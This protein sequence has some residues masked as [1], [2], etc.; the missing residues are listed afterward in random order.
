MVISPRPAHAS[1]IGV[2]RHDVVVVGERYLTDG[3]LPVLLNYFSIE[4]FPHFCFG[5]TLAVSIAD[6]ACLRSVAP[7]AF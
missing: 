5:A 4:Q 3:A 2:V 1:R 7:R 6:G